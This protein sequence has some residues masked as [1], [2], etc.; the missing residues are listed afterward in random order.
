MRRRL[1]GSLSAALA[2]VCDCDC[3]PSAG[4][5]NRKLADALEL[6]AAVPAD[7]EDEDEAEAE[8]DGG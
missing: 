6:A 2:A 7:E 3:L 1:F 4:L 5:S 8:F